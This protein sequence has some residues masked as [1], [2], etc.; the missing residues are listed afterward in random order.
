[1]K[2]KLLK[3][4]FVVLLCCG[5]L[6]QAVPITIQISGNITS[7]GG[8]SL[9]STIHTGSPFTGTYTYDSA[10]LDSYTNPQRGKYL[11]NSPYGISLSLGGYTFATAP[12]HVGQFEILITNDDSFNL[13]VTDYYTVFSGVNAAIPSLGFTIDNIIWNLRDSTHT[14]IFSDALPVTAPV[15]TNWNYNVLTIYAFDSLGYGISIHGTV[16]QATPEPATSILIMAGVFLLRR[17]R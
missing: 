12:S 3:F 15:L 6:T 11:Y 14:A 1:M 9:P 17:R 2:K 13:P 4:V 5:G 10:A 8:V 16:T 7:A